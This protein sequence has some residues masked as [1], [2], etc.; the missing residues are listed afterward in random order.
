MDHALDAGFT[1]RADGVLLAPEPVEHRDDE[2]DPAGFDAIRDM[3]ARHFW[4]RGRHRFLLH[5]V[6]Q[7]VRTFDAPRRDSLQAVD[8]GG[9]CGGWVSYLLTRA[10][11]LFRELALADSSTRALE[12]A[13][14]F[15]GPTVR[16]YQADLLRLPWSAGWDV[17]FLL[18]VLEH[19]PE[20]VEVLRQVYRALRPGG[21]L[22]VTTPALRAFWTYNDDLGHHV[23]R[24]SRRDFRRLAR[25]TGFEL[26]C[27]RYFLFFLSP[28]LLLSR[29]RRP[30]VEG[31]SAD[32]IRAHLR[33]THRVPVGAVNGALTMIFGME[34]PL[35]VWLPFPWGTSVLGVFRKLDEPALG[36]DSA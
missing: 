33:R 27:S 26:R 8:L 4:Y 20:D 11:G 2:Y 24:Y 22:F 34:T 28:L 17:A 1:R 7:A 18:D 19:I 36:A 3:Q 16:R 23:R 10:P 25:G 9:G 6:K 12:Y 32:A 35:G 15:V 5:S 30:N 31:L 13:R 29:L 21:Y 14:G